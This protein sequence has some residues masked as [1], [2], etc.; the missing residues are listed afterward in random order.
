MTRTKPRK[1]GAGEGRRKEEKEEQERQ[2]KMKMREGDEKNQV[3]ARWKNIK[4]CN[5]WRGIEVI[6]VAGQ[7]QQ[8]T[9]G[10]INRSKV[11]SSQRKK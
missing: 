7:N 11:Y 6:E 1:R 4:V 3:G 2:A 5:R 9:G 10:E 8:R